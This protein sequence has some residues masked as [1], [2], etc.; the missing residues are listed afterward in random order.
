MEPSFEWECAIKNH[1]E[2]EFERQPPDYGGFT[3]IVAAMGGKHSFL[4]FVFVVFTGLC[5]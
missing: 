3:K 5:N 2:T 4:L 1:L